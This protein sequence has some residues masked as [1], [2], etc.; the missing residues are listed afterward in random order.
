MIPYQ[1]LP[2][3]IKE[4]QKRNKIILSRRKV[5]LECNRVILPW[6]WLRRRDAHPRIRNSSWF[7]RMIFRHPT[8]WVGN[9]WVR[10][11]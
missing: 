8:L 11:L 9:K 2:R 6:G 3:H 5:Y 4:E 1:N 7:H 10:S